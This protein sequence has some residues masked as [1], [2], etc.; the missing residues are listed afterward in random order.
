MPAPHFPDPR[1]AGPER[2]VALGAE[3]W[4]GTRLVGGVYGIGYDGCFSGE[5][6]FHAAPDASKLALL[7]LVERLRSSGLAWMDI[8]MVTP[9]LEA[10]GARAIPRATFLDLLAR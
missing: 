8:Q 4:D 2:L 1:L 6:M 10:L 7:A 9:H 3:A 5:S